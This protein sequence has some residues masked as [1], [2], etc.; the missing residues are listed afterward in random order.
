MTTEADVGAQFGGARF[1]GYLNPAGPIR[2][3]FSFP[4]TV[5]IIYGVLMGFSVVGLSW[6]STWVAVGVLNLYGA[7]DGSPLFFFPWSFR[8]LS[9]RVVFRPIRIL[10]MAVVAGNVMIVVVGVLSIPLAISSSL[11]FHVLLFVHAK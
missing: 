9:E 2:L 8:W 1:G 4:T 7:P 6:G 3:R 5:K 10:V 11:P